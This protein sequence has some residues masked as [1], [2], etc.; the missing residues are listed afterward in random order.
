M[1]LMNDVKGVILAG[2]Y[3]KRLLPLTQTTPKPLLEI[4]EGYTILDKILFSLS[5]AGVKETYILIAHL[6]DKV[7]EKTGDSKFGMKLHYIEE[8]EPK[9]NLPALADVLSKI[10]SDII[11]INGDEVSDHNLTDLARAAKSSDDLMTMVLVEM[12]SPY[13][14][15][16]TQDRK[17]TAF[18]EKPKL[19][20]KVNAGYYYIKQ[21]AFK[22]F[23]QDHDTNSIEKSVFPMLA[24]MRKIGVFFEPGI[25]WQS[26]DSLKDLM[27]VQ[28]EY[29][30]KTDKPWGYEKVI[31]DNDKYLVKELYVK[32]GFQTSVHFHPKK[33]ESM[34]VMSGDG[35]IE[36]TES[37][38]HEVILPGSVV[39][40]E[41]NTH[42][43]IVAT[44]NLTIHEYS[45]PHPEDTV[46]VKDFYGR[47]EN[48]SKR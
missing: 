14:V 32:K 16:E 21:D 18:K 38:K 5:S 27:V 28:N 3:G 15:V 6:A 39:R 31:T 1:I 12:R 22:Y 44:E 29:R 20:L 45:T 7:K 9:G 42:H 17:V 37:G 19:E 4:R 24:D 10:E 33:D 26:V 35:R 46:R 2:G 8:K 40:I 13:G 25:F 36:L 34:H 30:N 11:L 48:E 23:L 43:T 47:S 41:P